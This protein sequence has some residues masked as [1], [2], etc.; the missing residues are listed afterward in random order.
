MFL[1]IERSGVADDFTSMGI[2]L[3]SNPT[4]Y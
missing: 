1:A 3:T 4:S 2:S